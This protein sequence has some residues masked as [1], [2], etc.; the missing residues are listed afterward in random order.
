M[1]LL[2]YVPPPAA[3][4]RG[5]SISGNVDY[6]VAPD[7]EWAIADRCLDAVAGKFALGASQH[8]VEGVHRLV[9]QAATDAEVLVALG[10]IQRQVNLAKSWARVRL[11]DGP[12]EVPDYVEGLWVK[13]PIS[14][15]RDLLGP[16]VA[17][18][19]RL[20]LDVIPLC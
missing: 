20:C 7:L 15:Y 17:Q 13:H 18:A 6:L 1:K 12:G 8:P 19:M 11:L 16:D 5:S 2:I 14:L 4:A 3:L 10:K 9:C